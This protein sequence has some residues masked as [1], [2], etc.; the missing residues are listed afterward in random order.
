[1][2]AIKEQE[3]GSCEVPVRPK[4]VD[5]NVLANMSLKALNALFGDRDISERLPLRLR[6]DAGMDEL[7]IERR[8]VARAPLIR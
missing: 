3:F 7:D 2:K 6:Q 5:L 4:T 1:M 8:R